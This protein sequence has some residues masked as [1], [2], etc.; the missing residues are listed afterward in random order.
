MKSPLSKSDK[1]KMNIIK[2]FMQY[3]RNQIEDLKP[4]ELD[5]EEY[6]IF[7]QEITEIFDF[8]TN[9]DKYMEAMNYYKTKKNK[10]INKYFKEGR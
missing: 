8:L 9:K 6:Q 5:I 1:I 2:G 4:G 10:S 7:R 3:G